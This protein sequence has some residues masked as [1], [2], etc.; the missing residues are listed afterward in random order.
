MWSKETHLDKKMAQ[1]F[2]NYHLVFNNYTFEEYGQLRSA[3]EKDS[4]T[5]YVIGEERGESGTPHLQGT[6]CFKNPR[7]FDAVKKKY[8]NKIHWETVKDLKGS[9]IYCKKDNQFVEFGK[10]PKGQGARTD[11]L[12]VRD[13]IGNGLRVDEIAMDNPMLYHQ[14]GRTLNK[15]EDLLMR[16]KC[17]TEMTTGI[18]YYG[19]TGVGKSHIAFD[20]FTPETHY[21]YPNDNGWWDGYT[22]QETVI[23]NDFRAEIPY[24]QMLQIVDKWP[25]TVRR[26]NREPMPFLSKTVIVTS[27]LPP[28]ELFTKRSEEDNIAQLLRRFEVIHLTGN[29]HSTEVLGG[30]TSAPSIIDS[31]NNINLHANY[32]DRPTFDGL[33]ESARASR[34]NSR[35]GLRPPLAE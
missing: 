29:R 31:M 26:R 32:L 21:V 20:G 27:S 16:K 4:T 13:S 15:I 22:Q 6:V 28:W 35:V 10:E 34:E 2:R 18:W 19:D 23:F 1:R 3:L 25:F 30:N 11:L 17:R 7:S 24:N 14:Y 12:E 8:N 9:I 5:Y 33:V